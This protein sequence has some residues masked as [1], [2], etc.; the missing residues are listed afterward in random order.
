MEEEQ[1]F[2][3][4]DMRR[5]LIHLQRVNSFRKEKSKF[6]TVPATKAE[7]PSNFLFEYM[8]QVPNC[9]SLKGS[10]SNTLFRDT[11]EIQ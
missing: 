5:A 4:L 7:K 6:V 10:G 1:K 9:I 8:G 2:H 11:V 3:C